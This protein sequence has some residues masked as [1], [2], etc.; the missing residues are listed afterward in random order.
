MSGRLIMAINKFVRV[1]AIILGCM[2]Y[3][4][5]AL[6][7]P[8]YA[9]N[10]SVLPLWDVVGHDVQPCRI[11]ERISGPK[12]VLLYGSVHQTCNVQVNTSMGYHVKIEILS[13]GEESSFIYVKRH[14]DL[15]KCKNRFVTIIT[16][17]EAC[18]VVLLHKSLQLN[19]Q[20][21]TSISVSVISASEFNPNCPESQ[22]QSN[23]DVMLN[24]KVNQTTVCTMVKGYTDYIQCDR[25]L[26][27]I[28]VCRLLF[29]SSCNATVRHREV[30]L[31]CENNGLYHTQELL[32]IYPITMS[33]L[34]LSNNNVVKFE[35]NL[36]GPS[37]DDPGVFWGM[38][39]LNQIL[40]NGNRLATIDKDLFH[41]LIFLTHLYMFDNMLTSLPST[42][43]NGLKHLNTLNMYGNQ[44]ITL[45]EHIFDD[46]D[47]L[48]VLHLNDNKLNTLPN[49]LFQRVL[50][51]RALYLNRNQLVLLP[52]TL[53]NG[54]FRLNTLFLYGNQIITLNESGFD[55]LVSL[56]VLQLNDN[57][58]IT[59]PGGLFQIVSN[60]NTLFLH[61]NQIVSLN[62]STFGGLRDLTVLTLAG[63]K[64]TSLPRGLFDGLINLRSLYLYENQLV[65]LDNGI[66]N[67][68]I[69]LSFLTLFVNEIN[70]LP[71]G[72]FRGLGQLITLDLFGN[73]LTTLPDG[74]FMDLK[75]L[76]ELYLHS[77]RLTILTSHVFDNLNNLKTL[78]I[79]SNMIKS[80]HDGELSEVRS[81][82]YLSLDR[83][84]FKYLR[85][86]T[87]HGFQYLKLLGLSANMITH[88]DV[89]I[90]KDTVAITYID[91]SNNSLVTIPTIEHL[92]SLHVLNVRNNLL[93]RTNHETFSVLP[94]NAELFASQHE[95]CECYVSAD[96]KCSASDNRSP[97]LTCDRLLSDRLLVVLMWLIGINALGG[98]VFVLIWRQMKT[99][100][101]KVQDILLNNLAMS[102]SL[103]GLY[104]VIVASADM[105]YAGNFP[106]QSETWRQGI[107]CRISGALSISS[108]ELSVFFLVLISIDRFTGVKYPYS[109]NKLGKRSTIII[110]LLIWLFS[111]ALGV[112]PSI[113]AGKNFKF[114]DN[115][116]VCI[117]LPLA[118]TKTYSSYKNSTVIHIGTLWFNEYTYTTKFTGLENGLYFSTAI[119]LGL[120]SMCY[121][122][123]LGCYI[124]IFRA[125]IRT[126]MKAGRTPQLDE[127]IRLTTKVTAIV[128]TDFMCI[129]PIIVL[130][131]LVQGR[132]IELPASVFAW[133][134]TFVLPINSAINP[135]LYTIS[136]IISNYGKNKRRQ[137]CPTNATTSENLTATNHTTTM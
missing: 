6:N 76:N 49:G 102:D 107:T 57:K 34:D 52:D 48:A 118:L 86:N 22:S 115:S 25:D 110:S 84:K 137:K 121:L 62:E 27:P 30:W 39:M 20:G 70:V 80:L 14:G 37:G 54:L 26:V 128:V 5:M 96:I 73:K 66:F 90:F 101:Y 3:N 133:A 41:G 50:N 2:F 60:L 65:T 51:L 15:T 42:L 100:K 120:N 91:L 132:I 104:M 129:F 8:V 136:E 28:G 63:N 123:I 11:Q 109:S 98:N 1:S 83:N 125:V 114:Y 68:L 75:N 17:T 124:E 112:I 74:I 92:T 88:I 35:I 7:R 87:L 56:A 13:N 113:L 105:Y 64:L 47:N 29:P 99:K 135:Y 81:L 10:F 18:A 126:A 19:L 40:I 33:I 94:A 134:V 131:I 117:G 82:E 116:H 78:I 95:I 93:T 89:D 61:R 71:S 4:I 77:N 119:F 45:H 44:L 67:D 85:N 32:I 69:S 103:M 21:N 127:Q 72:V 23:D 43:F 24:P 122:I 36:Q 111:V 97:Y 108:T 46:L 12:D 31:Q 16:N 53:F 79:H 9:D 38:H 58:L 130:G 55:D 106:M 59:L